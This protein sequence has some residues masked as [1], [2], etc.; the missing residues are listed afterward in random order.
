MMTKEEALC[1]FLASLKTSLNNAAVYFKDHPVFLK[2]A[3]DLKAK[4]D[5]L[6]VSLSPIKI[7]ISPNS[8]FIDG[9]NWEKSGLSKEL[10]SFLHFRKVETIE[11]KSGVSLKELIFFISKVSLAPKEILKEGGIEA[12]LKKENLS[13]I[14][15]KGLD[16]SRLLGVQGKEYKD[17]WTHMFQEAA[18]K[19]TPEDIFGLADNF[20]KIIEK[21]KVNDLLEN[22]DLRENI[23]NFLNYLK[24]EARDKFNA[25]LREMANLILRDK[26]IFKADQ[27]GTLRVF[28][29]DLSG[30]E[31]SGILWEAAVSNKDFDALSF[32]LLSSFLDKNQHERA[33]SSLA[34]KIKTKNPPEVN[35]QAVKR[36]KELFFAAKDQ[37]QA[38]DPYRK[39]LEFLFKNTFFEESGSRGLDLESTRA[40]YQFLILNLLIGEKNKTKLSLLKDLVKEE[41]DSVIKNKDTEFLRHFLEICERRRMEASFSGIFNPIK[42]DAFS[43]IEN[44]IFQGAPRG[45][46][47]GF[48]NLLNRSFLGERYYLDKI[49]NENRTSSGILK[50]YFKFFPEALNVF[51]DN[52]KKKPP[53]T[54]FLK[55]LIEAVQE[56]HSGLSLEILKNIFSFSHSLIKLE[57]LKAMRKLQERDENFLFAILKEENVFLRKEALGVLVYKEGPGSVAGQNNAVAEA[58]KLLLEVPDSWGRKNKVL[59][60]NIDI[61]VEE[62][63]AAQARDFLLVLSGRGFFWSKKVK[64]KAK[65]ALESLFE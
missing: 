55:N 35:P 11:I 16:Y 5:S 59:E 50:M 7:G 3:E 1:D 61:V 49:F 44:I 26:T 23:H 28:F 18:E 62:G 40:S 6:L 43:S 39:N 42:N 21:F 48:L 31:F 15:A 12:I 30:D 34:D 36:L 17:I 10:A 47:E 20:A 56:I 14:L 38:Y 64:E 24:N 2:S 19:G 33:A 53:D 52:L 51:Y 32:E 9:K 60:E 58:L 46:F 27:I 8:L 57:I 65:A 22:E 25:C 37:T 13:Y 4:A 41:L 45:E 29:K 54:E 63:L